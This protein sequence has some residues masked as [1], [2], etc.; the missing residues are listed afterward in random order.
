M[1]FVSLVLV[2]LLGALYYATTPALTLDSMGLWFLLMLS[3]GGLGIALL[4]AEARRR[5]NA[6]YS[7]G[8]RDF[9]PSKQF[10]AP[11][12]VAG[13]SL[14]LFLGLVIG[15][16]PMLR[17]ESYRALLG[18]EQSK[19][20]EKS[21]PPIDAQNA[22]LVSYEMAQRAAEKKLSEIPA[23]GSQAKIGELQK[24]RVK[25]SLYWV[26]FLEHRGLFTYLGQGYTPGYVMVSATDASDVKLVTEVAGKK[27][28]LRYLDSAYFGSNAERMLRFSGYATRGLADFSPEVDEEGNPF[29][30]ATVFDRMV[31]ALGY[32][33]RGVV[34]LDVQTGQ[35][36]FYP[37]QS[38]PAWVDRV[39][40]EALVREQIADRLEYVNGWLNPSNKDKLAISGDLDVVYGVDGSSYFYAGLTSVGRDGGLIGFMLVDTRTKE[41]TRYSLVGVTESVAQAA[42]EGVMPEK[43]YRA[44]NALPFLVEGQTPAY[45]MALQDSTGIARAYAVV[46]LRDYQRVAVAD[47]L[48]AAVRAFQSKSNIDRTSLNGTSR[49]NEVLIKA[50]V[51]RIGQEVRQGNSTYVLMLEGQGGKLFSADI[52][53]SEDLVVT[54]KGDTVEI[55][56]LVNDQ[57]V[58]PVLDFK[59]LTVTSNAPEATNPAPK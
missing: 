37:L 38:V 50:L 6:R 43:K 34:V 49:P 31:G 56:T 2:T 5:E 32:D 48:S 39:Q 29:L 57:R 10:L 9:V 44:T 35:H 41:V 40:P 46:D 15:S 19:D 42:T 21:L 45:V 1:I 54:Q 58:V 33:A 30:V 17:A 20:F 14:V 36:Q 25:D 18:A 59:N 22:P 3:S 51:K 47:T 16:M 52:N 27:L 11:L 23:L 4:L 53:R 13:V 12:V 24:Q 28:A 8:S 26:G 7:S 55:T